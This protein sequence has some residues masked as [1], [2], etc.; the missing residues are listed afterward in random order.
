MRTLIRQA[1]N[2]LHLAS[3]W[4]CVDLAH[5]C[6]GVVFLYVGDVELPGVVAVVGDRE[7]WILGHHMSVD[8]Q[9]GL[10]VRLDPSHLNRADTQVF[11]N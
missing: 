10:A 6:S 3:H 9:D 2:I 11:S 5:I 1:I 8:G 4:V 7:A